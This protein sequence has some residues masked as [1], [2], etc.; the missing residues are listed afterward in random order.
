MNHS[1][2]IKNAT[3]SILL[4]MY[5]NINANGKD[6]TR[7][8]R[9]TFI[10][11]HIKRYL[12]FEPSKSMKARFTEILVTH[13]KCKNHNLERSVISLNDLS[14]EDRNDASLQLGI[15]NLLIDEYNLFYSGLSAESLT[16]LVKN[17]IYIDPKCIDNNYT[18]SGD[19]I[20]SVNV[21]IVS[22]HATEIIEKV[23][24][25][26]SLYVRAV[27]GSKKGHICLELHP[28]RF[29]NTNYRNKVL[30]NEVEEEFQLREL[31]NDLLSKVIGG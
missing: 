27:I 12:R 23:L 2:E 31:D 13:K 28:E 3:T 10:I 18:E 16:R 22:D 17:T 15:V 26:T 30:N 21:F 14:D 11:K 24:N 20:K 1:V 29:K 5:S 8:E 6:W 19:L 25:Y 4:A 9:N 7:K